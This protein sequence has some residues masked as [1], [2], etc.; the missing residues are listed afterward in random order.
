MSQ[1]PVD[2]AI[3]EESGID[4]P[5]KSLL[6][7]RS[8]TPVK[9]YIARSLG[10]FTPKA[11][12]AESCNKISTDESL[13]QKLS[14]I[15]ESS[16]TNSPTHD[17]QVVNNYPK[18]S[19]EKSPR[20]LSSESQ[21][22]IELNSPK[23]LEAYMD[24]HQ[25]SLTSKSLKSNSPRKL[26]KV[27][28]KKAKSKTRRSSTKFESPINMV[29]SRKCKSDEMQISR[30]V[31][32]VVT[33]KNSPRKVATP[34]SSGYISTLEVSTQRTESPRAFAKTICT[35][36]TTPKKVGPLKTS[37]KNM[38]KSLNFPSKN[39]ATPTSLRKVKMP[40]VYLKKPVSPKT[41]PNKVAAPGTP[42]GKSPKTSQKH[43]GSKAIPM[44]AS[45]RSEKKPSKA[46]L[47][48]VSSPKDVVKWV[49]SSSDT[50]NI[51]V[52]RVATPRKDASPKITVKKAVTP[53]DVAY[54]KA[55][56][57][58]T[59]QS[60][61]SV[62]LVASPSSPKEM[63][64]PKSLFEKTG[65]PKSLSKITSPKSLSKKITSSKSLSKKMTS[66]KSL[67]KKITSPK[68]VA[69]ITSSKAL[70][71]KVASPKSLTK[72]VASPKSLTNRIAS[73]R[74]VASLRSPTKE[75]PSPR[76][77]Q[78][79]E[80]SPRSPPKK[81]ASTRTP[82]KKVT[83]LRSPPKKVATPRSPSKKAASPIL[84]SKKVTSPRSPPK[85]VTSPKS[86]PKKVASPIL[87]P[88]K[89]M[90]SRSPPKK[91]TS[92]RS[93][94]KKV[95][96]PRSPPKKVTSPRSPHKKVTSPRSP[97]K[98]VT[99]PR[100]PPKKVTSPRSPPK[101]VT[102]Y[103]SPPKKVASHRSPHKKVTSP[104][105]PPKKVTSP[106]SPPKKVT[107]HR[108]P[109]KKVASPRSPPKK[110]ASP[111]SP[112]MRT[113]SPKSQPKKVASPKS[114]P[115]KVPSPRSPTKRTVSPKSPLRKVASS[116]SPSKKVPSPRSHTKRTV[117]PKSPLRKA[118]SSR[119]PSKV[120]SPRSLSKKITSPK[121]PIA[122]VSP[123]TDFKAESPISKYVSDDITSPKISSTRSLLKMA[124]PNT[125]SKKLA[126][127]R[128]LPKKLASPKSAPLDLLSKN[129]MS[130]KSSPQKMASYELSPTKAATPQSSP[131][132]ALS[133]QASRK[134]SSQKAASSKS[135]SKESPSKSPWNKVTLHSLQRE[136]LALLNAPSQEKRKRSMTPKLNVSKRI[137]MTVTT[138]KTGRK[139]TPAKLSGKTPKKSWADVLKGG[140]ITR[141]MPPCNTQDSKKA[142]RMKAASATRELKLLKKH[143]SVDKPKGLEFGRLTTGHANSPSPIIIHNKTSK[144]PRF[145][146]KGQKILLQAGQTK[147]SESDAYLDGLARLMATPEATFDK[148]IT[149]AT[150]GTDSNGEYSEEITSPNT[151]I[152]V[153][154]SCDQEM[155]KT[156]GMSPWPLRKTRSF[157]TKSPEFSKS[158]DNPGS[159]TKSYAITP[160]SVKIPRASASDLEESLG[161]SPISFMPTTPNAL[162]SVPSVSRR[163][164]SYISTS[165]S[166][167][168]T[169]FDFS[170]FKTPDVTEDKYVSPLLTP[171]TFRKTPERL[172]RSSKDKFVMTSP[173]DIP[174][175]TDV[176]T[177]DFDNAHTPDF[178][179]GDFVSPMST[180]SKHTTP[181]VNYSFR[182]S[183]RNHD[184]FGMKNPSPPKL[185]NET[186][187]GTQS[188]VHE[189]IRV[190][191]TPKTASS[192]PKLDCNV[193]GSNEN[194]G[195]RNHEL[196]VSFETEAKVGKQLR[197]PK[198]V[199]GSP[200]TDHTNN[201]YFMKLRKS[202]QKTPDA[203]F[204]N[205]TSSKMQ[206]ITPNISVPEHKT[207]DTNTSGMRRVLRTPRPMAGSPMVD[208]TNGDGLKKLMT[209]P[210]AAAQYVPEADYTDVAGMK[211]L[212]KTPKPSVSGEAVDDHISGIRKLL[213]SPKPVQESPTAD[214]T[215]FSGLRKL[216]KTPN[217]STQESPEAD[218]TNVAGVKKL[219]RT[220]KAS[221]PEHEVGDTHII[222]IR[223]VLRTP[224]PMAELPEADYTNVTGVKKLMKT[225][226]YNVQESPKADYTNVK[227][228]KKLL[229][230]PKEGFPEREADYTH[231]AG[232]RKIL[233]TP[234]P[235]VDSPV[236]EADDTHI[237][238]LRK[239]FHS[240]RLTSGS[241]KADYTNVVGLKRL[242]KSPNKAI[243][244]QHTADYSNVAGIKRLLRS[245]RRAQRETEAV[246][247]YSSVQGLQKILRS[248]RKKTKERSPDYRE[249]KG[250][251]KLL[252]TPR[253]KQ[254]SPLSDY[255]NV[256]GVKNIFA[257]PV[258][259]MEA[260]NI[261]GAEVLMGTPKVHN[262]FDDVDLQGLGQVLKTPL[263]DQTNVVVGRAVE[264]AG[265]SSTPG[266][267]RKLRRPRK[268]VSPATSSPS[269]NIP[270]L[271]G[272]KGNAEVLE[273][274]QEQDGVSTP[275]RSQRNAKV[276]L[277]NVSTPVRRGRSCKQ[278]TKEGSDVDGSVLKLI[279][280]SPVVPERR[281]RSKKIVCSVEDSTETV[282]RRKTKKTQKESSERSQDSDLISQADQESPSQ[283]AIKQA[284]KE[285][286]NSSSLKVGN[287]NEVNLDISNPQLT[288]DF[289]PLPNTRRLNHKQRDLDVPTTRGRRGKQTRLT[290]EEE[291]TEPASTSMENTV[292][293]LSS[294]K[295]DELT[296]EM[297]VPSHKRKKQT[298][299]DTAEETK[300]HT[301]LRRGH[302]RRKAAEANEVST[303]GT[304]KVQVQSLH[305]DE[306]VDVGRAS[307]DIILENIPPLPKVRK[308]KVQEVTEMCPQV[309]I[310]A[311]DSEVCLRRGRRKAVGKTDTGLEQQLRGRKNCNE[312]I[313]GVQDKPGSTA[314]PSGEQETET[315][316]HEYTQNN[317]ILEDYES[318]GQADKR[319]KSNTR[320]R[321]KKMHEIVTAAGSEDSLRATEDEQKSL[322]GPLTKNMKS[323]ESS[324]KSKKNEENNKESE[325]NESQL[326]TRNTRSKRVNA[327]KVESPP[328]KRRAHTREGGETTRITRSRNKSVK[329]EDSPAKVTRQT[330][331]RK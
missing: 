145:C 254:F 309:Q 136:M 226:N 153:V 182:K 88:K 287:F 200:K 102:S 33:P 326:Q 178:S 82:L 321:S 238:G 214:Y 207:D 297:S 276:G 320:S 138:P 93:P 206:I 14:K 8:P 114:H 54:S 303:K 101:K 251:K 46:A 45:P 95:T 78:K 202:P 59:K 32:N 168:N 314:D 106:R 296:S 122:K 203:G 68:S 199:L 189:M 204:T 137:R 218:Y 187:K 66:P 152:S 128:S 135:F 325:P 146:R 18:M 149:S 3:T 257:S 264:L 116:T 20:L 81:V 219:M 259:S 21:G 263:A 288:L 51:A 237:I 231:V 300:A 133:S 155:V 19:P 249:P 84:P 329:T 40:E 165:A 209:A 327:E 315:C 36:K 185:I 28:V 258:K 198:S 233:R 124:S 15:Q 42:K 260:D 250:L 35:P 58:E 208:Y 223:K 49:A 205:V 283:T 134:S 308:I 180:R 48:K 72:K 151:K 7:R 55:T 312:Q 69:K 176:T 37:P 190:L 112:T 90:L 11:F 63:I 215:N 275:R 225:P 252:A 150:S 96:S 107:S 97:H 265:H 244:K 98:K 256:A 141:G 50:P 111:R 75:V 271:E 201:A 160:C 1:A 89:V 274:A 292:S 148:Q 39:L 110:T 197:T 70:T 162:H 140:L 31:S 232:I 143:L 216:M 108:S 103:R 294:G 299:P 104:R 253:Q 94:S 119:S 328:C 316:N 38:V 2:I 121:M 184:L 129:V 246:S 212:M 34:K 282:I 261:H 169:S 44:K 272:I 123:K 74:K 281:L 262:K 192:T 306:C 164:L 222:G 85:K 120:S 330:R 230:T 83:S 100:S 71:K 289:S 109:P 22:L 87:P 27:I 139:K 10:L 242:M 144:T 113:A 220:P 211:K 248:P 30:T 240:P 9:P 26:H 16:V 47:Q 273:E 131:R 91:V 295:S 235:Q 307:P 5:T 277:Q 86:P 170:S 13:K 65:S 166:L 279:K 62:T 284:A 156:Q 177:F 79:T 247:D 179:R 173:E 61:S 117:S 92:P 186:P 115:K 270:P 239:I 293:K 195:Q 245:P 188:Y 43:A 221:V 313:K 24:S 322:S 278:T 243:P 157:C 158:S 227:G 319:K 301:P 213:Q 310:P 67:D 286:Q 127:P 23:Y 147:S 236:H 73:P 167:I 60:K 171:N 290:K 191:C 268:V 241:P 298:E 53:Q 193:A 318:V 41:S 154:S 323:K 324:G 57:K 194:V 12:D 224:K 331:S 161:G 118:A 130:P 77:S 17:E 99:S 210:S 196:N 174:L 267:G 305:G 132:K 280:T 175:E 302:G 234:K 317:T 64:S 142:K 255:T 304:S 80:P 217:S 291:S 266:S 228:V 4:T 25:V 163:P 105:S 172:L 125:V 181:R 159:V 56:S 269:E 229:K 126:S 183:P 6:R 29:G 52:S 311:K 285:R 76:S